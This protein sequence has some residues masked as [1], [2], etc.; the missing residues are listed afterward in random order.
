MSRPHP[1][2]RLKAML[3][4]SLKNFH[5][6]VYVITAPGF[7]DRQ[8]TARKELGDGHFEFIF[9]THRDSTSKEEL[10]A[11]GT[12]DE[13]RAIDLD[14]S[15]KPMSLGHICCS[16][17]HRNVYRRIVENN[18]E[19]ALVFEDDVV[20][21]EV[22]ESKIAEIVENVPPEAE[23]IY[24]GWRDGGYKPFF[25]SIKQ[26]LYHLQHSLGV[27]KYDHTMISNLYAEPYN[28]FF[29][30]AGKRLLGHAYTVT[31]S[32]AEKLIE[33]NTPIA[34]NADN[35]LLYA[36]LQGKVRAYISKTQL[37]GQRSNDVTDPLQ[38]QTAF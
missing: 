28:A 7:E 5:D 23:L 21:F 36:V 33:L 16:I 12:Y 35:A 9:G 22:E 6:G 37:F 30:T 2:C 17:G 20:N 8:Q 31:R 26:G 13:G 34:L 15:R 32:A 19:R 24:W 1:S 10:M 14:R 38:T 29:D 3:S 4:P 25:G 11:N 18:I 27:L